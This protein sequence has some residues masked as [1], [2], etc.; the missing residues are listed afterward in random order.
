MLESTLLTGHQFRDD[1]RRQDITHADSRH[2]GNHFWTMSY[3]LVKRFVYG[4]GAQQQQS[5]IRVRRY[6]WFVFRWSFDH[7]VAR[8]IGFNND[9]MGAAVHKQF[10]WLFRL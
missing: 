1:S 6:D 2:A 5:N 3:V 7:A 8:T 9:N 10:V 4:F